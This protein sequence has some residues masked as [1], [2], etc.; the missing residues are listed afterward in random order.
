MHF[1]LFRVICHACLVWIFVG[2]GTIHPE[3]VLAQ[4]IS[5]LVTSRVDEAV[6]AT[7]TGNVHPLARPEFDK[8][9]A[10]DDMAMNR[11]VLVLRRTPQQTEA[12][13]SLIENQ[14]NR[15]SAQFHHWLTP[16]EIGANFGPADSDIAAATDWLRS[17]GFAVSRV[18]ASRM[19]IEFSGNAGLVR[20]AFHT[21]IHS[22]VVRGE[23]Y[24]ANAQEPTVPAALAPLIAGVNSLNS[25]PRVAQNHFTGIRSLRGTGTNTGSPDYTYPGNGG[26]NYDVTP[27]DFAAIYDLLPLWNGT[28]VVRGTG[29]TI[30]IVS[31]SDV[32]PSDANSF[33]T[34]FGLDGTHENEPTLVRTFDGP[35]PGKTAD[36]SEADIDTQWSGAAAPGATI[37]MVVSASTETTDGVDLSALYIVDN[38]LAP[39]MSDSFGSC[40]AS[41]G[42]TGV[43]FY[44]SLWQQAA[45]QGISVFVSSGDNGAAG[46]DDASGPAKNGLNVNGLASTAFNVAVG[47]TD[48][49]EYNDWSTYWNAT[50][51][52]ITSLSAKGY[53]P[54]TS[55]ND[56]CSNSLLQYVSSGTTNPEANC[57]NTTFKSFLNSISGSG[58]ASSSWMKPVWQTGTSSD[59]ARDLPDVSL[60]A[61]NGFLGSSYVICQ[62]DLLNEPCNLS[63]LAGYGGT[64]VAS[65]A[66]AGIMALVDQT[67]G[68]A[69]GLPGLILYKLAAHQANAFHDI[70]SGTTNAVPC[71]TGS[72]SCSTL[73][74]GDAYG[75]TTGYTTAT[76][77][78]LVTG[79]GS[80]DAANLAKNWNTISFSPS[81]TTLSLNGG[82][83]VSMVHGSSVPVTISVSPSGATGVAA[84][85]ESPG[86]PGPGIEDFALVGGAFSGST[87]MLPGGNYSVMAHYSG[88]ANYGGSYSNPVDVTVT[89]EGS[90]VLPNLVTIDVNG[91]ITS[92][93]AANATYGSGY[94]LFRVDVGDSTASISSAGISSHCASRT[95]SCPTGNVTLQAPGTQLDGLVLSLNSEGYAEVLSPAPGTYAIVAS[96]SGDASY[97]PSSATVTFTVA[98]APTTATAGFAGTPV[99]YGNPEQIGADITTTSEGIAPTGTFQ[100]YVDGQ[101]AGGPQPVYESGGY[102]PTNTATPW[103]WA[104]AQT[105]YA[106]LAVGQHTLSASYSGDSH[107]A[108]SMSPTVNV[109]VT[110]AQTSFAT[111]WWGTSSASIGQTVTPTGTI[112]GS[113]Q[114]V[115]PT[116]T[117]TFMDNGTVI[118]Q[119]SSFVSGPGTE[120]TASLSY[121]FT[122]PGNHA[123]TASYS[124]DANYLAATTPASN[125]LSV[126]GPITA[127]AGS[128]T[129]SSPGQSGTTTVTITPNGG[130]SGAVTLSCSVPAAALETTCG[131]GTGTNLSPTLQVSVNGSPATTNFSVTTTAPHQVASLSIWQSSGMAYAVLLGLFAPLFYRHRRIYM[132]LLAAMLI[133]GQTACSGGGNSGESG[134]G[135]SK[136]DPG[137]PAATYYNGFKVTAQIGSGATAYS[138]STYVIV[139][140]Q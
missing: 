100:F 44:G 102:Q 116:G 81:S 50:N 69:Q 68:A 82:A 122:T 121:T 129:I 61:S 8:G 54:E 83:A 131:F 76:G 46:C 79:I 96:Y 33:W 132:V 22:Y 71:I 16:Q 98:K 15:N 78:D 5:P 103:P 23:S 14:Q 59:N 63:N 117:M 136:T 137:T 43:Q 93:S 128:I 125:I 77:Y 139:A 67:G 37:N 51:D 65:P 72:P 25:F 73:K 109:N 6:R 106:F 56:S 41:L 84:L 127:S 107:Y 58:G 35:N 95:A 88:D 90:V 40:E 119:S 120:V 134:S 66:M 29:E 101:P 140:V 108:A 38:N 114:G 111:L 4:Q 21:P 48:F 49:N 28:P 9:E 26:T 115:S 52:P 135:G 112:Y 36:E 7:L 18:S 91:K 133:F 70:P 87:T 138:T 10:R 12:L 45:A 53:I 123:L 11:L 110:Q 27:F 97:A 20:Q 1:P 19:F 62:S 89:P 118:G 86:Q 130:F 124:G 3:A 113:P 126:A 34:L 13:E 57:N 30:A 104:D 32:N 39:I 55:W 75:I 2:L 17:S 99:Q 24:W 42:S 80:V 85:M 47:G 64:S 92:H 31:R 105:T 74:A 60:F 94:Q